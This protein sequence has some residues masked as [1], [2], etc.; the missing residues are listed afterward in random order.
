[1]KKLFILMSLAVIGWLTTTNLFA[2]DVAGKWEGTMIWQPEQKLGGNSTAANTLI[3]SLTYSQVGNFEYLKGRWAAQDG[4]TGVMEFRRDYN[5]VPLADGKVKSDFVTVENDTFYFIKNG[6]FFLALNDG[7]DGV[8]S[9]K[10]AEETAR[11]WKFETAPAQF[12]KAFRIV[13]VGKDDKCLTVVDGEK[14]ELADKADADADPAGAQYWRFERKG[15]DVIIVNIKNGGKGI[16]I[17]DEGSGQ[18]IIRSHNEAGT[19]T[20][21]KEN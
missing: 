5:G 3:R 17:E 8:I 15:A 14:I 13:P 4:T 7:K 11:K 1:M 19:W 6:D 20:L 18:T 2:Q 16:Y 12:N 9:K 21:E 10:D